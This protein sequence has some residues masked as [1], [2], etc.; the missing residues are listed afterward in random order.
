MTGIIDGTV[1]TAIAG[2]IFDADVIITVA[3]AIITIITIITNTTIITIITTNTTTT[4]T[5][6]TTN[7]TR[8]VAIHSGDRLATWLLGGWR[9]VVI[10]NSTH[11]IQQLMPGHNCFAIPQR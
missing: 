6:T 4:I 3:G 1:I 10:V 7:T 8:V 11:H 5:N 9:F 2:M